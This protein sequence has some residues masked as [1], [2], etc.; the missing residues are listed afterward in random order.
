MPKKKVK[1]KTWKGLTSLRES[2]DIV[3]DGEVI[4]IIEELSANEI[5]NFIQTLYSSDDL[6]SDQPEVELP[7]SKIGY[8]LRKMVKQIDFENLTDEE[9]VDTLEQ[10]SE[11]ITNQINDIMNEFITKKVYKRIENF[12]NLVGEMGNLD[13]AIK[14]INTM[15]V[16]KGI[17][18]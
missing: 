12:S 4:F 7:K 11:N 18:Q 5:D 13:E 3:L 6:E 8:L 16:N 17:V 14:K 15:K 10:F 1:T 2:K 9:I